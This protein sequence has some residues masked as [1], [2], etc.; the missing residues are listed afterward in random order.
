MSINNGRCIH[1]NRELLTGD[2]DG[3]CNVCKERVRNQKEPIN[4]EDKQVGYVKSIKIVNG[5]PVYEIEITDEETIK[6]ICNGN[7]KPMSV[8]YKNK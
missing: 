8:G 7:L 5:K 3:V 4:Y 6:M 1:C 2:F